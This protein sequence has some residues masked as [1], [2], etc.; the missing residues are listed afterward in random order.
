[1]ARIWAVWALVTFIFEL[2][3]HFHSLH[4]LVP[5][6]GEEGTGLFYL[7]IPVLDGKLALYHWLPNVGEG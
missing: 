5:D 4:D 6:T 3:H 1:L 2:Y 7:G